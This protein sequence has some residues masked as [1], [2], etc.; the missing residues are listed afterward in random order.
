[1]SIFLFPRCHS[2]HGDCARKPDDGK[3][4]FGAQVD[5]Y[6]CYNAHS[7]SRES[8]RARVEG[9]KTRLRA[10]EKA[11]GLDLPMPKATPND[12]T[13]PFTAAGRLHAAPAQTLGPPTPRGA[14]AANK[15]TK[16]FA[17][18]PEGNFATC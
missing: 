9:T 16:T 13:P 6:D 2:T 5:A 8:F 3:V 4:R 12:P 18:K 1:M 15:E 7:K 17:S 14:A 10:T 11:N